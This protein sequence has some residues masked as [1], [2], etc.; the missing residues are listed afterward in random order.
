MKEVKVKIIQ[1]NLAWN[2]LTR[3]V[4]SQGCQDGEGHIDPEVHGHNAARSHRI[5]A[6]RTMTTNTSVLI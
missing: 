3:A 6:R 4:S 5:R 1:N 2:F